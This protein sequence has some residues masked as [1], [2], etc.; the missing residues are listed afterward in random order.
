ME[1]EPGA[2]GSPAFRFGMSSLGKDQPDSDPSSGS[3][4]VKS[5]CDDLGDGRTDAW[6]FADP[7]SQSLELFKAR[8]ACI[9]NG[10]PGFDG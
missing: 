8:D 6:D 5:V 2:C 3:Q 7:G 1:G 4:A 9:V 10:P